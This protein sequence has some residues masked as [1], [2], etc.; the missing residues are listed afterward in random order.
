MINGKPGHG[1]QHFD[2]TVGEK[3]AY[4]MGKLYEFRAQQKELIGT[5]SFMDVAKVTTVNMTK[6]SGGVQVNVIPP[7]ITLTYDMRIA[8]DVDLV[9][10]EAQ[11][12]EWCKEAGGEIDIIFER[13]D[14]A[15]ATTKMDES[16]RYWTAMKEATDELGLE[17]EPCIC[18]GATDMLF[19]R[20]QGIPAFGFSPMNKT[21][22]LAHDH[23]ECLDAG[24]YLRGIEIYQTILTKL[25]ELP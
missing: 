20:A 5:T 18:P 11:L 19:V 13:K 6:L 12:W 8:V 23:D 15:A 24:V 1:S 2:G 16:N 14:P 25:A 21:P 9:Q 17:L 3:A 4:I 22:V 7:Q 10:W